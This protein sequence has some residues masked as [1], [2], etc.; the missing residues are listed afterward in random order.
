[1]K[2]PTHADIVDPY[3]PPDLSFVPASPAKEKRAERTLKFVAVLMLIL[4]GLT[5]LGGVRQF[6]SAVFPTRF[7]QPYRQMG[8]PEIDAAW[9]IWRQGAL[10]VQAKYLIVTGALGAAGL[11][12]GAVGCVAA[13]VV[14]KK[15]RRLRMLLFFAIIA[16]MVLEGVAL[17]PNVMMQWEM[18]D[19]SETMADQVPEGFGRSVLEWSTRGGTILLM[20]LGLVFASV[21]LG[22]YIYGLTVVRRPEIVELFPDE[23]PPSD[24]IPAQLA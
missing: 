1:M 18:L 5:F 3:R 20:L 12:A 16:L 11:A 19:I 13:Y 15:P 9:E 2:K 10:H 7:A 4:S 8:D 21:K 22:F 23:R 14:L 17:L 24:T 6:V